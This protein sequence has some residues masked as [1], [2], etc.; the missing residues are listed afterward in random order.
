MKPK[1][2]VDIAIIG[3]GIVGLATAYQLTQRSPQLTIAILEKE[4]GLAQHQTGHNS[5]VIHS[6]LYYRPGSLKARTCT[7]GRKALVEFAKKHKIPHEICGKIVVAT[8]PREIPRLEQLYERGQQN[9]IEG[10]Q[11]INADQIKSFEPHCNGIDG[12]HVPCTGII[13]FVAVAQALA[14]EV[15]AANSA[16]R[17]LTGHQVTGFDRHDFAIVLQT[18]QGPLKARG[19]INCGG[20]QSDR[21]A[22]MDHIFPHGPYCTFSRRILRPD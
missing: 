21:I 8:S 14:Q 12:L 13:D 9:G 20:L 17:I 15:Q 22:R 18:N 11:R 1:T 3:G 7:A 19:V 5:G 6:G 2:D 10:F 4:E 16:N